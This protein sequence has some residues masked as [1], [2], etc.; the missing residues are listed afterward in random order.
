[1]NNFWRKQESNTPL[2]P[3]MLWNKPENRELAGKLTIV[4]GNEHGF[5]A[6]AAAYKMALMLGVGKV[7]VVLPDILKKVINDQIANSASNSSSPTTASIQSIRQRGSFVTLTDIVFTPS[8]I[9]GGFSRDAFSDLNTMADWADLMLFIGDSGQNSETAALIEN[10]L[11]HNKKT[12]IVITRDAIELV[13]N[14]GES[15]LNREKT[16]LVVSLSQLQK[17]FQSVYY[18]RMVLFSQGVK[19]IAETLRKFTITYPVTIT[20]FHGENL[21]VAQDGQVISQNFSQ[22]LR[23]WSGEIATRAAVWQTWN[24]TKNFEAVATSWA[25]L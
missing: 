16:H 1:M 14:I 25:G 18:P 12:P 21:F 4:G 22:A 15:L 7:R 17:I 2:F 3:D 20:L 13:K 19:Q 8:N 24:P 23:V 5:A 11:S 6:T 10:F 9:S